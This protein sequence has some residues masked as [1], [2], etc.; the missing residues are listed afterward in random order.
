MNM[1]STRIKSSKS[2]QVFT[3]IN[4]TILIILF[5]ALIYPL[6][7]VLSASF[8]SPEV[9]SRGEM[10]LFPQK[11]TIVG[12][13]RIFENN[14]VWKGFANTIINTVLGTILN[15]FVTIPC[16]YALSRKDMP[17]RRILIVYFMVTMYFNSGIIPHYLNVRSLGLLNTRA[18]LIIGGAV[19]VYN[20]IVCKSF[21]GTTIPWVLHEAARIDG[22]NDTR[23][24]FEIILPLSKPI[25]VVIALY[26]AV[27]HWN[28]YFIAMVY[29][30]DRRLFPL[31][32]FLREILLQ[33]KFAVAMA[34]SGADAESIQYMYNEQEVANQLKYG[35]IVVS[36]L[37]MMLIYPF[38]QRFFEKG[39]M[40][41]SVKG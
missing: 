38:L 31:Q 3:V 34:M 20:V 24:F 22:A 6:V 19:S 1:S 12:Y 13:K 16:G 14:D 32:L 35:I 18:I 25:I 33:S 21:F 9:V 28:S 2:D 40:I 39:I 23:T 4:G 37:P 27:G 17:L 26:C 11:I 36:T 15:L 41:G 29:I 5:I 10:I 8:S 7:F 30:Q